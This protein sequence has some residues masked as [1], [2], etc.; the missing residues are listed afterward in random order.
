MVAAEQ[1]K[2]PFT[3]EDSMSS[4]MVVSSFC[5]SSAISCVPRNPGE[6][7]LGP[8]AL[9]A[10]PEI[11]QAF[12]HHPTLRGDELEEALYKVRSTQGDSIDMFSMFSFVL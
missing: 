10:L 8:M 5:R 6:Q 7:V 9:E 2:A 12:L 3:V 11:R 1:L 4:S